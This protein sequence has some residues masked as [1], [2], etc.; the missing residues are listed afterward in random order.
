[1]WTQVE[2]F[3]GT[4]SVCVDD[5]APYMCKVL[6]NGDEVGDQILSAVVTSNDEPDREQ[7]RCRSP[8]RSSFPN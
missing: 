5:T 6:P 7:P 8:F 1:M 3:L 4:R 2:F